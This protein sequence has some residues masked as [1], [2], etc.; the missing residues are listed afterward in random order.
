MTK[1]LLT[2]SLLIPLTAMSAAAQAGQTITDKSYWPNEAHQS[3]QARTAVTRPDLNSAFAFDGS[4]YGPS[5]ERTTD[6][7]ALTRNYRGGPKFQ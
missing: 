4:A 3:V 2:I 1:T 7:S 5:S 6:R